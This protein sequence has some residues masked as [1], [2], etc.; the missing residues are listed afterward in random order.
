[1]GFRSS[2]AV[3]VASVL[4]AGAW[5]IC[6]QLAGLGIGGSSAAAGLLAIIAFGLTLWLTRP[7]RSPAQF[8]RSARAEPSLTRKP[9]DPHGVFVEPP[10]RPSERGRRTPK[11]PATAPNAQDKPAREWPWTLVTQQIEFVVD[12]AGMQVRGKRKT[13]GGEVWEEYLR[14]RWSA[15]TALGFAIGSHDSIPALYARAAVG[16]PAHVA[17][18]PL[19]SNSEWAQLADLIAEATRGRLTLDV[20]S[21][22]NTRSAWPDW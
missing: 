2:L 13:V 15:V 22:R 10:A 1:M 19:L 14:I 8:I 6:D 20:A 18:S 17:D 11:R 7:Y 5:A 4:F 12:D 16:K 9:A 3:V 21:R